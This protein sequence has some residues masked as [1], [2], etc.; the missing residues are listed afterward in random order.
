MTKEHECKI[1]NFA[2]ATFNI[3]KM[4]EKERRKQTLEAFY[5]LSDHLDGGY[6]PK[7]AK[8]NDK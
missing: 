4:Q 1:I 3:R 6:R 2:E 5:K 8:N 7:D